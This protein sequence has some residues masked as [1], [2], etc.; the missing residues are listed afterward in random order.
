MNQEFV[1]SDVLRFS[2]RHLRPEVSD[3]SAAEPAPEGEARRPLRLRL[4]RLR[5]VT[6]SGTATVLL[7]KT[8]YSLAA[9]EL[10]Q[11]TL[12]LILKGECSCT[13][14][15]LSRLVWTRLF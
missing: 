4:Q 10:L 11:G 7:P 15:L 14:D 1:F 5:E 9:V 2:V 12:T 6:F 3:E 8:C 13:P